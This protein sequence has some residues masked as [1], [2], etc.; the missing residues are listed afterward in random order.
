MW[1]LKTKG[2]TF[3][4]HHMDSDCAFSTKETPDNPA[5]KGSIKYKNCWLSIDANS[6]AKLTKESDNDRLTE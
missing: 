2:E 3:Y 4:I 6:N 5:T 1:V